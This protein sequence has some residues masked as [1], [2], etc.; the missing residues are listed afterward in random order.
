MDMNKIKKTAPWRG[1][2]LSIVITLVSSLLSFVAT[3]AKATTPTPIYDFQAANYLATTGVWTN[4][5]SIPGSV[6]V[7]KKNVGTP[8]PV[9][10]SEPHSVS[11]VGSNE[12]EFITTTGSSWARSESVV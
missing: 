3:P 8:D 9:K 5:G 11:F 1:L 7:S 2:H 4:N 12:H 10:V 6:T